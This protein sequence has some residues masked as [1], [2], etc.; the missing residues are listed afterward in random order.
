MASIKKGVSIY[1]RV[2]A[3][4]FILMERV[5]MLKWSLKGWKPRP[6]ALEAQK[7]YIGM[8]QAIFRF[9]EKV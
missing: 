7:M 1:V 6:F 2:S 5:A 4:V 8:N 3:L 9:V